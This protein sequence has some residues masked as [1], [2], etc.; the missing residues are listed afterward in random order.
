MFKCDCDIAGTGIG[1]R[2]VIIPL[3]ISGYDSIQKIQCFSV[4]AAVNIISGCAQMKTV[5]TFTVV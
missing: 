2:A 1:K 5:F 3:S 4:I